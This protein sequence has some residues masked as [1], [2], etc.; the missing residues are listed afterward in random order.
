VA[1]TSGEPERSI[2]YARSAV[3]LAD[4]RP[5][6]ELQ[7]RLRRRLAQSL[8]ILDGRQAEAR[9]VIEQAWRL[10]AERPPSEVRAWVLAVYATILRGEN[11]IDAARERAEQAVTDARAVSA[12][13]ARADA[14]T[15]LA[16]LTEGSGKVEKA[17][18]LLDEA[19]RKAVEAGALSVE[20]RTWF[21]L[22]LHSYELGRLDEAARVIDA[23]VER[24]RLTGMTWST[25][26]LELRII[27][28]IS[29]YVTGDWDGSDAAGEP[30]GHRVSSTVSARMAAVGAPVMVA[31]GRFAEAERLVNDLRS[32]RHRDLQIAL[33]LGAAAAELT[34]WRG[35]PERAVA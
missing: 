33:V 21:M 1:T 31:R 3:K 20:A 8:Y 27:Q 5:D 28:V 4:Q 17:R 6:P 29:R 34:C 16:V 30:P 12:A 19:Q 10:V 32:E 14:L 24:A 7:A 25:Y 13:A 2:A 15:T 11:A 22:A 18:E 26:G 35:R 9:D 23:G